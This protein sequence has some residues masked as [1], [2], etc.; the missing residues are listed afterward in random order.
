MGWPVELESTKPRATTA[1]LVRFGISHRLIS[2]TPFTHDGE[3][4]RPSGRVM[5]LLTES[6]Y[7][8]IFFEWFRGQGSN[9]DYWVQ[10][11]MTCQL[12]YL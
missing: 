6:P 4:Y 11:P 7:N 12:V 10:S 2:L 5:A 1:G 8:E 9:L 3:G